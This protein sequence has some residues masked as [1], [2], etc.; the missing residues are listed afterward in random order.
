MERKFKRYLDDCF[1]IW[2]TSLGMIQSFV[3]ILN[4]LDENINF[5]LNESKDDMPFLDFLIKRETNN[6]LTTEIQHITPTIAA[7]VYKIFQ[8][9]KV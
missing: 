5:T 9:F 3:E 4:N 7:R 1:I 2:D 6:I 8:V